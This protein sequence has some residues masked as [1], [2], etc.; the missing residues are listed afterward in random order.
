MKW[1][2]ERCIAMYTVMCIIMIPVN[3]ERFRFRSRRNL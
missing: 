3:L 1:S 2:L